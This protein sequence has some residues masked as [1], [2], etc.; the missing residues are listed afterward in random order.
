MVLRLSSG[1]SRGLSGQR[2]VRAMVRAYI[3]KIHMLENYCALGVR[4]G[5][6]ITVHKIGVH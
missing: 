2:F 5:I 3:R 1:T 4:T 6:D